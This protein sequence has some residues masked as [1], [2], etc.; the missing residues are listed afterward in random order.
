MCQISAAASGCRYGSRTPAMC[1]H[2]CIC[3]SLEDSGLV[4]SHRNTNLLDLDL[5]KRAIAL[6]TGDELH[7]VRC[8]CVHGRGSGPALGVR[9]G[10]G[11]EGAELASDS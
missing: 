3:S 5:A 11:A 7:V 2:V 9:D 8:A 6:T 1:V 10:G 4:C